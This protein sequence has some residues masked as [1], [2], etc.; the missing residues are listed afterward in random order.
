MTEEIWKDIKEFEGTYQVSNRGNVRSLD[1]TV[2]TNNGYRRGLKGK[3]VIKMTDRYGYSYVN[4]STSPKYK[5][6]KVHRLVAQAF[7]PN[8]ENKPQ[9]NHINGIKTDN[10]VEN[11]EWCTG[12]EN[13]KHASDNKLTV[14]GEK[15]P[16]SILTEQN[17]LQI[18]KLY[19]DGLTIR[20]L[21]KRYNVA[22]PTIRDTI[23]K[24]RWKHLL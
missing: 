12:K 21:S 23:S 14:F 3:N 2:I 1:R 22:Y 9:V 5:S 13:A 17:V 15:H 18:R 6:K 11:L 7:I 8:P 24:R 16:K 4:L 10:R 20:E 19:Q